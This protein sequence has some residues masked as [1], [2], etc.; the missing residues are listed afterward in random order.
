MKVCKI[1]G[2]NK[3]Y[4]AK[5]YC[6]KHYQRWKKY[7]NPLIT[8]R[9]IPSP[10]L[11]AAKMKRCSMCGKIKFITEFY[12]DKYKK[13][14]HTHC[15]KNCSEVKKSKWLLEMKK[16]FNGLYTVWRNIKRRCYSVNSFDFKW[17]GER[18]ITVCKEWRNSFQ[19]F[20]DWAKDKHKK[21]LEID[22]LNNNGNYCPENCR[23]ITHTENMRNS[24]SAKLNVEKVRK[25]RELLKKGKLSQEKIGKIFGVEQAVISKVKLKVSWADVI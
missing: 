7:K 6:S 24:S 9:Y 18:G 8:K 20:Y 23:F 10:E 22:R 16:K 14:K 13:D 25:I 21:E 5:G 17:Y 3:L 2:C 15:C 12:R 19:A 1:K 11:I 4:E